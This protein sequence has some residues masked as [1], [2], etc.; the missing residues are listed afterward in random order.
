VFQTQDVCCEVSFP[1][2]GC[3]QRPDQVSHSYMIMRVAVTSFISYIQVTPVAE[4]HTSN[5]SC[6]ALRL[7]SNITKTGCCIDG[8][9]CTAMHSTDQPRRL[10]VHECVSHSRVELC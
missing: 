4:A 3:T 5:A 8:V 10:C 7:P 6:A 1:D 2:G 9:Q